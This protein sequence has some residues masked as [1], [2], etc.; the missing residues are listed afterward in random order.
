MG[1]T[2]RKDG[3]YVEFRVLDDGKTLTLARGV[4]GAKLKRWKTGTPNRT[5]AKQQEA[6]I[7]TDLMKGIVKSER[8]LPVPFSEWAE[9]YLTLEEVK[10]LNTYQDRVESVRFQLISFFGKKPLVEIT[11]TDVEAF[12]V[13][14]KLRNGDVPTTA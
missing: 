4:A 14:R 5:L 1:L 9:T 11:P 12:R 6:I 3:W 8:N 2:R 7:K 10:A 13:Q